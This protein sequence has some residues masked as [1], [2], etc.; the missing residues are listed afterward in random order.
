M[1]V[2]S[3]GEDVSGTAR[4]WR[5]RQQRERALVVA[6]SPD[7]ETWRQGNY[8]PAL[9]AVAGRV[10]GLGGVWHVDIAHDDDCAIWRGEPCD[11]EPEVRLRGDPRDN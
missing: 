2:V 5:R 11:C 6:D 9:M 7:L 4:A 10:A 3:R 1:C 8:V